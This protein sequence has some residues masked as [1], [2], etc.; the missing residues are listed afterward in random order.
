[1][2]RAKR[3]TGRDA[4]LTAAMQLIS[5]RGLQGLTMR[6]VATV[7]EMSLGLTTYH[8]ADRDALLRETLQRFVDTELERYERLLADL[9][10]THASVEEILDAL[11]AGIHATFRRPG[12]TVALLEVC[13]AGARDPAMSTIATRCID[14]Y[15]R[16]TE[17][18]L[19]TTGVRA[20][21]AVRT[22]RWAM[23]LI[24]GF[25]TQAAAAG[26]PTQLPADIGYA[27]R[28]LAAL[29]QEFVEVPEIPEQS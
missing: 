4:L 3:G 18:A 23:V 8:F 7:A 2:A 5:E 26:T 6:D 28:A 21:Q 9:T 25:A 15:R 13:L 24:D 27:I 29:G 19:I 16:L 10:K 14:G 22:A 11:V 20:D 12:Y 17:Q 1:M